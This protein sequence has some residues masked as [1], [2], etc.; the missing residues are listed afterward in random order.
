MIFWVRKNMDSYWLPAELN[1]IQHAVL[2]MVLTHNQRFDMFSCGK[3]KFLTMASLFSE[4]IYDI[5][6]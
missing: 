2:M 4:T 5:L 6:D 3:R 1:A